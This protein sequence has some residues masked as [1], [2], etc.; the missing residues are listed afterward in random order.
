MSHFAAGLLLRARLGNGRIRGTFTRTALAVGLLLALTAALLYAIAVLGTAHLLASISDVGPVARVVA[1][2][3]G[4]DVHA[5]LALEMAGDIGTGRLALWPDRESLIPTH[6]GDGLLQSAL[7]FLF[8]VVFPGGS[9]LV[10]VHILLLVVH[11]SFAFLGAALVV[12]PLS[13]PRPGRHLLGW[14]GVLFLGIGAGSQVMVSWQPGTGGDIIL[15]MV[16]TKIFEID[17]DNYRALESI[18][19]AVL[20]AALNLIFLA[21]AVAAGFS[22]AW[23]ITMAIRRGFG[24]PEVPWPLVRKA[25]IVAGLTVTVFQTPLRPAIAIDRSAGRLASETRAV[26]SLIDSSAALPSEPSQAVIV[27]GPVGY[28]Y[29]V[30][31]KPQQIRCIGYNPMTAHETEA[32]RIVRYDRDFAMIRAA[33]V[34]TILGWNQQLFDDDVL[35]SRA[36]AHGLGV[37]PHFDL[38]PRWNY[39]DPALFA[40]VS[41]AAARWARRLKS[42]PS[43]RMWGLG[44]EVIHKYAQQYAAPDS[45]RTR[46]FASFLV[47]I[48][49]VIHREDPN[50]PVLYRDAEDVFLPPILTALRADGASRPWFVYGMN[51]YTF[52][53]DAAL[54]DGPSRTSGQPLLVSEFAPLG[55]AP[56][57][58]PIGYLKLWGI[59]RRNGDRVLGG[60]AYVWT[61]AGPEPVDRTLG[62]TDDA[63][64]PVDESLASLAAVFGR[65]AM[66]GTTARQVLGPLPA[67]GLRKGGY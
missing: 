1:A 39:E 36:A 14:L 45:R 59:V 55:L 23:L 37:I 52:R 25:L 35:L 19:G 18:A 65:E 41:Q 29:E 56:F 32:T 10:G 46:A 40:Q 63:G 7:P 24:R 57:D 48:A 33:S 11:L 26:A 27:S 49:D 21:V 51:F 9:S 67:S 6:L 66:L 2:A 13:T 34:N 60:C 61:T 53:L 42:K 17:G 47:R 4:D 64:K 54:R 15:G 8:G 5:L 58:R 22:A 30:N 38:D 62:L 28:E 50:H 12:Y 43:L 3:P 16:S 44:N 31:G 20:S